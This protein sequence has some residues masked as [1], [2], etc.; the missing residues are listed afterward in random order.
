MQFIVEKRG[1]RLLPIR[2]LALALATAFRRDR[3]AVLDELA[4]WQDW[5]RD[6]LL[7]QSQAEE[8]A[9]NGDRLD[10]LRLDASRHGREEIAAFVREL[11]S[12]RQYLE[13]NVQP[14]LVLEALLIQAPGAA[15]PV[16]KR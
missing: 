12:S 6:V 13:D 8:G 11:R 1:Y 3:D 10:D 7:V 9:G 4:A 15:E 5:W 2:A 14:R 16:R